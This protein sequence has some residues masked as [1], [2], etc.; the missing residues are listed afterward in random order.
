MNGVIGMKRV[1]I[2]YARLSLALIVAVAATGCATPPKTLYYW[3]DYQPQVYAHLKGDGTSLDAQRIKLE[4]TAQLAQAK[5]DPLPPGFNAHLGLLYLKAGQA[6][7]ARTAFQL[8]EAQFPESKAY[9]DFLLKKFEQQK[10]S[11]VR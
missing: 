2:A 7:K 8:E 6:D 5:G 1:R 9:M 4:A 11:D 10:V 3:G